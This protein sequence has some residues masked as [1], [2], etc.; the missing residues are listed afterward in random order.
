MRILIA[1]DE[2]MTR[3][4]LEMILKQAGHQ[5]VVA[6]DGLQALSEF[7]KEP[8]PVVFSDWQ[9]P[10]MCGLTLCKEIRKIQGA[11]KP[12]IVMITAER[13]EKK[14]QEAI[15]AGVDDL[16]TK[17]V[18]VED[19]QHWGKVTL[20]KWERQFMSRTVHLA[21]PKPTPITTPQPA[22]A[23]STPAVARNQTNPKPV[24]PPEA[25]RKRQEG[26]A[27]LGVKI[28]ADGLPK[29]V[30]IKQSSGFS[31]L[32]EAAI[33]AVKRW[34]FEPAMTAGVPVATYSEVPIRFSL[35]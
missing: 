3:M 14:R 20:E 5:V 4:I 15:S 7:R 35:S 11:D 17:P 6:A 13:G 29:E 25:R 27:R 30:V 23:Q 28:G 32:D 9:M 16:I 22:P 2:E 19:F 18:D 26:V 33:Q 1:E 8:F 24:Y 21:T 12:L 10:S 34:T 31:S